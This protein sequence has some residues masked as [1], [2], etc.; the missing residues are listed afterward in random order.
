M[1]K[2]YKT[3]TQPLPSSVREIAVVHSTRALVEL[4]RRGA[5][6]HWPEEPEEIDMGGTLSFERI[7]FSCP[8][9]EVYSETHLGGAETD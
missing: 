4:V 5:D 2:W 6:G 8:L 3:P 7:G 1:K 9:I